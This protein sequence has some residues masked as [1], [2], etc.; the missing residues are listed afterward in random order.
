[1]NIL[2]PI[3]IYPSVQSKP[4]LQYTCAQLTSVTQ[5]NISASSLIKS[6]PAEKKENV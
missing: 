1:M 5:Q 4:S 2:K 3:Q 6:F